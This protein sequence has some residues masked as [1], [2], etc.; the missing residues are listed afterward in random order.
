MRKALTSLLIFYTSFFLL[1][2]II[3]EFG[4]KSQSHS[5]NGEK[6]EVY[7]RMGKTETILTDGHH[8]YTDGTETQVTFYDSPLGKK[9]KEMWD[10]LNEQPKRRHFKARKR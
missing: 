10:K 8:I 1:V 4:K 6:T 2:S 9:L 5:E 3:Q 7:K